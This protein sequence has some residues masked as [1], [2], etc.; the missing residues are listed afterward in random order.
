MRP[1]RERRGPDR[2]LT[3]KMTLFVAAAAVGLTA[4]ATGSRM[5]GAV[6]IGLVITAIL[7]RFADRRRGD[8]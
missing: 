3:A 7:L 1:A 4:M 6:A 8:S 2:F 5:F